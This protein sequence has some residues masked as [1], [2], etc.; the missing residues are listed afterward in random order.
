MFINVSVSLCLSVFSRHILG[1]RICVMLSGSKTSLLDS[2]L[3]QF[4]ATLETQ[5]CIIT[6]SKPWNSHDTF[7]RQIFVFCIA[8]II[9]VNCTPHFTRFL[10]FTCLFVLICK[11]KHIKKIVCGFLTKTLWNKANKAEFNKNARKCKLDCKFNSKFKCNSY[12][13]CKN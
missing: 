12:Q 9:V 3:S 2:V 4:H 8:V 11:R 7:E 10:Y 1:F 6:L 13:K 5:N